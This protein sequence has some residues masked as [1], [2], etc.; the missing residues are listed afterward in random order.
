MSPTQILTSGINI[1]HSPP[2]D[3]ILQLAG[4]AYGTLFSLWKKFFNILVD[5]PD[6]V[7]ATNPNYLSERRV[8][9][10]PS[11]PGCDT[12]D[13]DRELREDYQNLL[14]V[15]PRLVNVLTHKSTD[16][17]ARLLTKGRESFRNCQ[18]HS[19]S[20]AISLWSTHFSIP[21]PKHLRGVNSDVCG[22][23][24]CLPLHN[25]DDPM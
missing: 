8:P 18:I 6:L 4:K 23:L 11:E 25:W 3:A 21:G 5:G 20:G 19:I 22:A 24:L 15:D 13:R 10:L 9:H 7:R 14:S 17:A 16:Q 2:D 1:L 12:L